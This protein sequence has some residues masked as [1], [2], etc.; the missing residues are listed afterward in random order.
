M[1]AS[2]CSG[3]YVHSAAFD[4]TRIGYCNWTGELSTSHPVVGRLVFNFKVQKSCQN[5]RISS[6]ENKRNTE[7]MH[8]CTTLPKKKKQRGDTSMNYGHPILIL[9]HFGPCWALV[10]SNQVLRY[11]ASSHRM[12]WCQKWMEVM[13][14]E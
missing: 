2:C 7:H 5:S 13:A 8:N 11:R 3:F 6:F 4:P 12:A 1:K 14:E 10:H 9:I